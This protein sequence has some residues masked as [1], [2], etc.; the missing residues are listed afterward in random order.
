M[1]LLPWDPDVET[2]V[3]RIESGVLDLQPDFQRGEVW[4][5]GKK[6]RLIDSIL[7]DWH[8]P[9]IHVI[10]N[11]TSKGQEVLDG[12]QRLAAIRDFVRGEFEVDGKTEPADKRIERLNGLRYAKLPEDAKRQFDQFTLRIYRIVDYK[13]S[14]PAELFFR[15][16]QPTNLTSAEQRNAFF[17]PVRQQIKELAEE[18]I[19]QNL[20]KTLIG[21]SNSRMAYDDVICRVALTLERRTIAQKISAND[22]VAM[23]RSEQP[24][25]ERNY[26]LLSKALRLF[27]AAGKCEL[28][29]PRLNK[30]TLYSWLVFL[31]RS[32]LNEESDAKIHPNLLAEFMSYF[33]DAFLFSSAFGDFPSKNE[34]N[35]KILADWLFRAYEDRSTSRVAD[36]SSVV[37]RDVVIWF[38]FA[39]FIEEKKSLSITTPISKLVHRVALSSLPYDSDALT[40]E[41]IDSGWSKF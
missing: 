38:A 29:H 30:A 40:K 14:E 32:V 37:L 33:E 16:N 6:Q 19:S 2:V 15:L 34:S 9:P 4:S 39:S 11:S 5:K 12:Q 27:C 13:S 18:L 35:S 8:V 17:G 7:R 24:L 26:Q 36:V 3:S 31:T 22:L 23:Y 1:R 10:E 25:A 28:P 20:P 21:F 41:A